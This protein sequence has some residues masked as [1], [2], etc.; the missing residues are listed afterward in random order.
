MTAMTDNEVLDTILAELQ[1]QLDGGSVLVDSQVTDAIYEVAPRGL[2]GR[3]AAILLREIMSRRRAH[4]LARRAT[5]VGKMASL[6]KP[7]LH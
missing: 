4:L 1:R 2:H 3:L 7:P 5:L 6:P